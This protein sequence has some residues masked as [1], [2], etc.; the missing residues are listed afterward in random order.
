[1]IAPFGGWFISKKNRYNCFQ[2]KLT[3][4]SAKSKES[5]V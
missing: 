3:N 5:I 2:V 1:M 4:D